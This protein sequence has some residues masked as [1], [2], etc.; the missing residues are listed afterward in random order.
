M[1][2]QDGK[3]IVWT[4]EGKKKAV[5]SSLCDL[6]IQVPTQEQDVP[7]VKKMAYCEKSGLL[8][9]LYFGYMFRKYFH[10][11]VS[12]V[13]ERKSKFHKIFST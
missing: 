1:C 12:E 13:Y 3:V 9:V 6:T 10:V 7:G 11:K 5:F 2:V 8:A 4:L